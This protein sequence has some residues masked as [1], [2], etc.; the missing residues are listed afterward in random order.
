VKG[1]AWLVGLGLLLE[2]FRLTAL[3]RMAA[4]PD[5]LLGVVVLVG[6]YRPSPA[7]ALAGFGL[8]LLRDLSYG[9]APGVEMLPL[10]LVGWT[11]DAIGPVVY[12]E[13]LLTQA[14]IL[15]GAGLLGGAMR[16]LLLESGDPTG[17]MLYLVR[18][19]LPGSLLSALFLP[20]LAAGGVWVWKHRRELWRR[21]RKQLQVYERKI[22]VKR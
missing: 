20:P 4:H 19:V 18:I 17:L 16:Y 5:L 1:A 13:S 12:R 14:V 7:G 8:G 21:T 3:G 11:V 22:F 9:N 15:A 10:T 6:L 2:A